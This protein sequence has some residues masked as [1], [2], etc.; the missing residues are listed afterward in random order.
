MEGGDG[1]ISGS[2]PNVSRFFVLP[3]MFR[4]SGFGLGSGGDGRDGPHA[5]LARVLYHVV[6]ARKVQNILLASRYYYSS[7]I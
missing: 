7:S 5:A 4:V 1:G 3:G 2:A 6:V